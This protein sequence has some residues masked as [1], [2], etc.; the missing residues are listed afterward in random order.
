MFA[1]VL[2]NIYI[3]RIKILKRVR[4]LRRERLFAKLSSEPY[5]KLKD[6]KKAPSSWCMHYQVIRPLS[7]YE[8][9]DEDNERKMNLKYVG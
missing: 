4:N 7:D 2:F 5:T 3:E 1:E 6:Q 8:D 9:S